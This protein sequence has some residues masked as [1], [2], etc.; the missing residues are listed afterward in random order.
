[1]NEQATKTRWKARLDL[2]FEQRGMRTIVSRRQ[3]EGPLVI[4][5]PFYPEGNPC[6]IY[7][8]H[9]PGGLVGGDQL[10]LDVTLARHA[11]TLIT[12]PGAS[13]FY[14]SSGLPAVQHQHFRIENDGLLEWLPQESILFDQANA[15]I[16]TE[17]DLVQTAKFIGWEILCLGRPA[18]QAYFENGFVD[19]NLKLTVEGKPRIIERALFE[20][21]ADIMTAKWGLANYKAVGTMLVLPANEDMLQLIRAE[22]RAVDNELFSATLMDEI[23]VCRYLGAQAEHIKRTF[24]RVWQ[25]VRPRMQNINACI[26]RI[27][28]T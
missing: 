16:V 26:P 15:N 4:Q 23:L 12:T 22:V 1:M 21:S 9:P 18:S 11:H 28:N 19:Q 8:L 24:T 5:K 13:K 17:V 2:R 7:L 20:G 14:R 25:I 6:H 3:H 27:W 10:L